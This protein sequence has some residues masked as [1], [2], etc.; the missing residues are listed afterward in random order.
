MT[1]PSGDLAPT[2]VNPPPSRSRVRLANRRFSISL[3]AISEAPNERTG[4]PLTHRAHTF[5]LKCRSQTLYQS[6]LFKDQFSFYNIPHIRTTGAA[7][8]SVGC[9]ADGG[10]SQPMVPTSKGPELARC[11][12]AASIM[13]RVLDPHQ[14]GASS[15][16]NALSFTTRNPLSSRVNPCA[17][18]EVWI[19]PHTM[20]SH[21]ALKL[22][23][24][25]PQHQFE[26][27]NPKIS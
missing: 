9:M 21:K 5:T 23:G 24:T 3:L 2:H 17:V 7:F 14:V 22:I 4:I 25:N 15:N 6:C 8:I 13:V 10:C 16:E 12:F 11:C 19:D 20:P 27:L 26:G 18:P 1:H